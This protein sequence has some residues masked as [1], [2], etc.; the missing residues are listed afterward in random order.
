MN[1]IKGNCTNKIVSNVP[2]CRKNFYKVY[3][4][5][6]FHCSNT[7]TDISC[8]LIELSEKSMNVKFEVSPAK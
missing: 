5:I 6:F 3:I 8:R 4:K 2:K 7:N 1:F